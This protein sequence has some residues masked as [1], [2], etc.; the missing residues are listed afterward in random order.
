MITRENVPLASLTT[1][2]VG[3]NARY[4]VEC[5]SIADV[6]EAISFARREKLP[7]APLGE[8]SNVLASDNGYPGVVL[9]I[10][11]P[12]IDA[13]DEGET[14]LLSAGA[15]VIWDQLVAQ[16]CVRGLWGLENL[17]GIPGTVGA[18]PV[19]NIGAYGA[20]VAQT[21]AYVDAIDSD[22]LEEVRISNESCEFGY[23]DSRFK[24]ERS[25]II[26]AVSFRLRK[27][28]SPSI[29]YADLRKKLEEGEKMETPKD[30]ARVVKEVRGH[31]FPDLR[32]HG[33]AG[34]FFKNPVISEEVYAQ[35]KER[36]PELPGFSQEGGVKIPIAWILD[37]VLTLRGY[38]M[39]DVSLFEN[40]PLVLVT[41]K[42]A[43][44]EDV[45]ALA[46]HITQEVLRVAS[47]RIEREVRAFE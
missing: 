22:S 28:G 5:E 46:E 10:R 16:A 13:K 39:G 38:T 44:A 37:H 33:T 47:V 45:N 40:Q 35:L 3:G 36:Y 2:R 9:H 43:R 41:K 7:Y 30:V 11:I 12:G 18:S 8:G 1:L 4:V 42:G 20:E 31:K 21:I 25:L 24:R 15:G 14:I 32:I 34:S 29:A 19:Q 23:R 17:A 6:R 27:H 26:T